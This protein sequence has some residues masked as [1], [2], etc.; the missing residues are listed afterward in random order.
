M[1]PRKRLPDIKKLAAEINKV[2]TS[3]KN[4]IG[5]SAAYL[6]GRAADLA[7]YGSADGLVKAIDG[8]VDARAHVFHLSALRAQIARELWARKAFIGPSVLDDLLYAAVAV[9]AAQDPV[10]RCLE[11]VRDRQLARPGLVIFPLHSL[12]VL[13]AGF[14]QSHGRRW[15]FIPPGAEIAIFP[16]T[17]AWDRTLA[18]LDEVRRGFGVRKAVP[19]DLLA[20][21]YRSRSLTWLKRNPILVLSVSSAPGSYYDTESLILGRLRAAS[22]LPSVTTLDESGGTRKTLTRRRNE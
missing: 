15:V 22:A 19:G 10:L 11:I 7:R 9:D 2:R 21:W 18:N 8:D 14:L 4:T 12:G 16:Q 5:K 13:A 1:A 6:H 17:N 20:H 3:G